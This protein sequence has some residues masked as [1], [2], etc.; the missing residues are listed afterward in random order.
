MRGRTA[1]AGVSWPGGLATAV[2]ARAIC[3]AGVCVSLTLMCALVSF[4][5]PTFLVALAGGVAA[6]FG[7]ATCRDADALGASGFFMAAFGAAVL[8]A[9][10]LAGIACGG[11]TTLVTAGLALAA[12]L[13]AILLATFFATTLAGG[14]TAASLAGAFL[15]VAFL[16]TVFLGI[17]IF[18]L[19]LVGAAFLLDFDTGVFFFI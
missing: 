5:L 18:D 11:T 17:D 15:E 19:A 16:A 10:A 7:T 13:G 4:K 6:S 12:G 1:G 3:R 9:T 2:E 8:G 14:L